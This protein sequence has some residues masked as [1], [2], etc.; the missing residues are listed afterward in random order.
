[1][2]L[3]C[4][5]LAPR[6]PFA[7][8]KDASARRAPVPESAPRHEEH[9]SV[10]AAV[11]ALTAGWFRSHRSVLR[12]S[13]GDWHP[14]SQFGAEEVGEANEMHSDA[15]NDQDTEDESDGSY[16]S[17]GTH[18]EML[19]D[20]ARTEAFRKAIFLTCKDKVVLEVGCGTGI[21]SVFA[22][23]AG[24]KQV[25]AAEANFEMAHYA[26]QVID[27]N[28]FSDKVTVIEGR[29]ED[30]DDI[31]DET[32]RAATENGK[33]DVIVSE[34]MGYMLVCEDMFPAVAFARNRWLAADG[35]MLPSSC[36]LWLAPFSHPALVDRMTGY[37][38]S[39]PYGVDLSVLAFPSLDQH[40]SQPVIDTISNSQTLGAPSLMFDLDCSLAEE[41]STKEQQCNF[42]FCVEKEGNFHGLAAWFSC[43][44]APGVGFSTGPDAVPTHWEQTLLFLDPGCE[45]FDEHLCKGDT[46]SGELR[47]LA[48]G[49]NLGVVIIG[50]A[51]NQSQQVLAFGRR[52]VLNVV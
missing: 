40:L 14:G 49:Y 29:I 38:G 24:A 44:L 15:R 5:R 10:L 33:A 39:R 51:K 7:F 13:L 35:I 45:S 46:V 4:D 52:L 50:E 28:G 42:S 19:E 12:K 6:T 47:W 20:S 25:I 36:K 41:Q 30:V 2:L 1:M 21:L 32:L 3:S 22:A 34:W 18:R 43:E 8:A 37:W 11:A 48:H 26:H 17:L 9:A 31:V 27:S 16:S 23:Q